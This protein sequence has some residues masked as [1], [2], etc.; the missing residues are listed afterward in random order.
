M[1][2][3]RV[4]SIVS[5]KVGTSPKAPDGVIVSGIATATTFEGNLTGNAT[6]NVTGNISGNITG[7]ISGAT[8]TFSGDVSVGGTITYEDVSSVDSVGVIT[9]RDGIRVGAGQSISAVSGIVTYY[10]DGSQ[11]TG[12]ESGAFNF[13]ASGTLSNGQTVL[14]NTDGTVSAVRQT[15][16]A[17]SFGSDQIWESDR[18]SNVD[19]AYI[20]GGK[21]VIGYEDYNDGA[22][23]K[24]IVAT[25]NNDKTVSFGTPYIWE[26][27]SNWDYLGMCYDSSADRVVFSYKNTSNN[28]LY[29]IVGQVS[30]TA[31]SFGSAVQVFGN[32]GGGGRPVLVHDSSVSRNV[33]CF[34]SSNNWGTSVVVSVSGTTLNVHNSFN[35]RSG[36]STY[37][38]VCYDSN[39]ERIVVGYCDQGASNLFRL[40]VGNVSSTSV[41]FGSEVT[42]SSDWVFHKALGFDPSVNKVI[43]YYAD[44]NAS[45]SGSSWGRIKVGTVDASNNTISFGSAATFAEYNVNQT[46]SHTYDSDKNVNY[47]AFRDLTTTK[48]N[49]ISHTT[50]GNN[51]SIGS[52]LNFTTQPGLSAKAA[53]FD[54]VSKNVV[55]TYQDYNNSNYGT[56]K[57]FA[58]GSTTNHLTSENYIGIAAAGISSGATGKINIATGI[59]EGQTGL[60][61]GQKYYVQNNGSLATS[62]DS[63]SVVAGTAI[64]STKIIVKG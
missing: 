39:A 12:V 30:G 25:V 52:T 35:F 51:V 13:T 9:A 56:S 60:T 23:G 64:S 38:A 53:L 37:I 59:N 49:L 5:R 33:V 48:G 42:I 2:D 11:L 55:I 3:L 28:T 40:K 18:V 54:T 26:S 22:K 57:V 62:A 15:V 45:G 4:S 6:G 27:S 29:G 14:I 34:R 44:Y 10:G 31:L 19:S 16:V 58:P 50:S 61:T 47:L 8:G 43:A 41:T 46:M 32:Y 1:S 7:N 36:Q 20:G 24:A 63:P 21:Y 17:D